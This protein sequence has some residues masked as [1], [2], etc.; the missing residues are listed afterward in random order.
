MCS[1][2]DD[3][4]GGDAKNIKHDAKKFEDK[5]IKLEKQDLLK[6]EH[7]VE[8]MD[9]KPDIKVIVQTVLE[10]HSAV[11]EMKKQVSLL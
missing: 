11:G 1:D 2:S 8:P 6:T 5:K 3:T 7:D 10:F 4:F 9:V